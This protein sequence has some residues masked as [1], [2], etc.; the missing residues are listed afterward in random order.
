MKQKEDEDNLKKLEGRLL[1]M[2][3]NIKNGN[4]PKEYTLAGINLSG[5]RTRILAGA[6]RTNMTLT[7]LHLSRKKI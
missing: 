6:L 5:P 7:A 2:A 4:T 1:I 3:N